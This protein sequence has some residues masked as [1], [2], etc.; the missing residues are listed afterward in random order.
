MTEEQSPEVIVVEQPKRLAPPEEYAQAFPILRF[1]VM[2][3]GKETPVGSCGVCGALT[4]IKDYPMHMANAHV[5]VQQMFAIAFSE[6]KVDNDM[7][8]IIR[9]VTDQAGREMHEEMVL[10]GFDMS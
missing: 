7:L 2:I 9:D 10:A 5:A 4:L 8:Q 3:E 6:E 1:A